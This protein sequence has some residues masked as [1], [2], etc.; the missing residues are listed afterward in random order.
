MK[1]VYIK[2]IRKNEARKLIPEFN[3]KFCY[4][5]VKQNDKLFMFVYVNEEQEL[6]EIEEAGFNILKIVNKIN[7]LGYIELENITNYF[8]NLLPAINKFKKGLIAYYPTPERNKSIIKF[9]TQ[10]DTVN[11]WD[12]SIKTENNTGI[13]ITTNGP[14]IPDDKITIF[15]AIERAKVLTN[16]PHNLLS[17]KRLK[18]ILTHTVTEE[19]VDVKVYNYKDLKQMGYN[20]ITAV[21]GTTRKA[22]ILHMSYKPKTNKET[23]RVILVGKG[24]HYDSG[25]YSIKPS[26]TMITMKYDKYGAIL[27]TTLI[28]LT[29]MLKLN[30]QVEVVIGLTENLI[31]SKSYKPGDVQ[32][33]KN[34]KTIEVINT[35]AEGRLVLADCLN[36]VNENLSPVYY[37]RDYLFTLATLT[38][39]TKRALG[40]YTAGIFGDEEVSKEIIKI[41]KGKTGE[42]FSYMEAHPKLKETLKSKIADLRNVA[43]TSLAGGITAYLF[44]KE[45]TN[46]AKYTHIDLASV[47][48]TE[49]PYASAEYG[50]TGFGIETLIEFISSLSK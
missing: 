41:G 48:W 12:G 13:V 45:F 11:I 33:S 21:G 3:D 49:T 7:A 22:Y 44:L 32:L 39:A 20:L 16:I 26:D 42:W 46:T 31:G 50:P 4:N 8:Y 36:Y 2:L 37:N 19:G 30:I 1:K 24:V 17:L 15:N 38:G 18:N 43:N 29:A 25:G 35:D 10:N 47:A 40:N 6:Y 34:G 27:A 14:V 23:R 5:I 28:E 9:I